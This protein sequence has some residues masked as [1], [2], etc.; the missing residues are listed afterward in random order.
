M[1]ALSARDVLLVWEA[2][3]ERHAVDRALLLLGAALPRRSR[4]ELA[5]LPVGQRDALLLTLRERTL[6]PRLSCFVRCPRCGGSLEFEAGVGELRVTDPFATPQREHAL[7]TGG[8]RVRFRLLDSRD[9]AAVAGQPDAAQA[10]RTLLARC[11]VEAADGDGPVPAARLPEAVLA[12]LS[13]AL[14][15]QDPQWELEFALAC[16][17]CGNAWTA[18]LDVASYFWT[19]LNTLARRLLRDVHALA[20]AYGWREAD[21]VAMSAARR[22][23]YLEMLA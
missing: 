13:A 6:G 16:G 5:A 11:V 3:R 21:I 18:G 1:R 20:S 19:E 9:L 15:E 10:R 23:A 22:S 14:V 8:Y 17:A 12:R 4:D 2:G 7:E